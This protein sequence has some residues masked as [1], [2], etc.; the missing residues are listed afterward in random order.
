[1]S[2]QTSTA[3]AAMLMATGL[4]TVIHA[5]DPGGPPGRGFDPHFGPDPSRLAALLGLSDEQQAQLKAMR[6][7]NRETLRPL[8]ESARRADHS[9]R[10]ALEEENPEATAVGQA[11]LA[12]HTARLKVQAA[13][14]AALEEMKAILTP[15]QGEKLEEARARFGPGRRRRPGGP[16]GE[17]G[18]AS[19]P[20]GAYR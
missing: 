1:M 9:F 11:A 17:S 3:A 20:G 2:R 10:S 16:E 4:V 14:A 19:G 7:K 5:Q 12:M 18:A 15:E 8:M 13:H 6:D